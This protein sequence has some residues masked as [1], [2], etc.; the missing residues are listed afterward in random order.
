MLI[1]A[2]VWVLFAAP[3]NVKGGARRKVQGLSL[4][5]RFAFL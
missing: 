4:R 2:P 1:V 3:K 5:R